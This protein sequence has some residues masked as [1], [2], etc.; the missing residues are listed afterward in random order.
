MTPKDVITPITTNRIKNKWEVGTFDIETI[1]AS[2][3]S[4]ALFGNFSLGATCLDSQGKTVAYFDNIK[5]M[6]EYMLSFH[7]KIRW[8][9]HNG[10]RFDFRYFLSDQDCVSWFSKLYQVKIIGGG[11]PKAIMFK[12]GKKT[13]LLCDSVKL[14]PDSLKNLSNAFNVETPKGEL[15]FDKEN[16]DRNNSLHREYLRSDVV[17]LFQVMTKYRDTMVKHFST[18]SKCTASST[19]FM[20]FRRTIDKNIFHHANEVNE[21]CRRGYYGAR[22]EMLFQGNIKGT[23]RYVDANSLYPYVMSTQ[24]SID[25]PYFTS[26]YNP[27]KPGFYE[28]ICEIPDTKFGP[29]P[30]RNKGLCFPVGKFATVASSVEINKALELGNKVEVIRGVCFDE[31]N[32]DLFKPFVEKC[33]ALRMTD[34]KGPIGLI[35]KFTQNNLYGFFG[36][37]PERED[38]TFSIECPSEDHIPLIDQLTGKQIKNCWTCQINETTVNMIPAYAAWITANARVFL[39]DAMLKEEARGNVVVNCDTDS[40]MECGDNPGLDI[41]P[42]YGQWKVEYLIPEAGYFGVSAKT[43]MIIQDNDKAVLRSKGI[44][45]RFMT[46]EMYY[47][48]IEGDTIEVSY[49]KVNGLK[50]TIKNRGM[51]E[52]AKRKMTKL[53]NISNRLSNGIGFTSPI[54]LDE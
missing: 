46:K 40:I 3:G 30:Y 54:K 38:I 41:G 15:D 47:K 16:F 52:M 51:G 19:A 14:M 42:D 5:N 53:E 45:A 4:S 29:L 6:L 35:A 50:S 1:P 11:V 39:L 7:D 28:C 34:Y 48:C 23:G 26:Q 8:F 2:E 32:K 31:W 22:T 17:S 18:D 12:R 37:N 36:M 25:R 10:A 27:D 21:F 44:P 43:Y 20:A 24:G 9:A 13:I 33:K 49:P